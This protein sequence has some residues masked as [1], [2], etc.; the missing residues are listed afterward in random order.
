MLWAM[1]GRVL[2][3]MEG[4]GTVSST[5]SPQGTQGGQPAWDGVPEA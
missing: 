3:A 1:A 5:L 2:G 4:R